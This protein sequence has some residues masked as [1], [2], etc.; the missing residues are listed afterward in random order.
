MSYSF[1]NNYKV[2]VSYFFFLSGLSFSQITIDSS[3]IPTTTGTDLINFEGYNAISFDFESTGENYSWDFSQADTL[4]GDT[5]TQQLLDPAQS[6]FPDVNLL[7]YR[8][9]EMPPGFHNLRKAHLELSENTLWFRTFEL[10]MIPQI[11]DSTTIIF[12]PGVQLLQ[13]PLSYQTQWIGTYTRKTYQGSTLT[14][15]I[16]V[17][18]D[19]EVDGW[20]EVSIP[21]GVY[22]CLRLKT[23]SS[24][25]IDSTST[26]EVFDSAYSWLT[27]SIPVIF[28]IIETS[29]DL[30][31][32][33]RYGQV[34][35]NVSNTVS[36]AQNNT[37]LSPDRYVL[38]QNYP[39]P[40]NPTT[41]ITYNIPELSFV[42]VKVY[43]I[44]GNDIATL[45]NEEKLAGRYDARF[46]GTGLSSGI[47][48][49]KLQA[50]NHHETKKMILL[51]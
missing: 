37:E 4:L 11:A 49:Y 8:D 41:I 27:N 23:I 35:Y 26:W 2:I 15:S 34:L 13:F 36:V 39:N 24:Q 17:Q 10:Y 38:N 12:E 40:F 48:F 29:T 47:Y 14:D 45:V 20:G 22:N 50:G 18:Y 43:D 9:W 44:L 19:M 32:G 16:L 51:Q 42:S 25:W 33:I 28:Q 7:V 46:D 31:T 21:N 3:D 5:T 6:I 30:A 1:K